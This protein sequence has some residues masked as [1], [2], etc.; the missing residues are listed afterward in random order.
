MS[1]WVLKWQTTYLRVKHKALGGQ[2]H[3]DLRFDQSIY[4]DSF[5]T[6]CWTYKHGR[7]SGHHGFVHLHHFVFLS[8][9]SARAKGKGEG[10][11]F[12]CCWNLV[13]INGVASGR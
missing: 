1:V 12:R 10:V 11:P 4:D 8:L 3:V 6:T 7:V 2:A 5:A 9:H 13:V